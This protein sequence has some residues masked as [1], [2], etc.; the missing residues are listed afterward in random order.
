MGISHGRLVAQ[1][2]ALDHPHLVNRLILAVTGAKA[3]EEKVKT[4][5]HWLA[6]ADESRWSDA[7]RGHSGKK[8]RPY[9]F[10]V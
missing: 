3:D 10:A 6:L 7:L 4:Y 1:H 9:K 8:L 5:R 2:L